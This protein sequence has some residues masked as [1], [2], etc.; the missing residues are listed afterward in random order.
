MQT[1]E[2]ADETRHANTR[3]EWLAATITCSPRTH[4]SDDRCVFLKPS[5]ETEN[6]DGPLEECAKKENGRGPTK[7]REGVAVVPMRV[8]KRASKGHRGRRMAGRHVC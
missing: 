1:K 8:S 4:R 3:G 7:G 6:A 5:S 2:R